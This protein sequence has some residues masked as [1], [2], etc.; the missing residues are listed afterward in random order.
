MT[1]HHG[2]FTF[3]HITVP[4]EFT[5]SNFV[6][7]H[8]CVIQPEIQSYETNFTLLTSTAEL[9]DKTNKQR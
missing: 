6:S 7:K 5:D 9:F 1:I 8:V 3:P 2:N 4:L